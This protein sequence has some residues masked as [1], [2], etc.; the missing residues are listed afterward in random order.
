MKA[1]GQNRHK[2]QSLDGSKN[3]LCKGSTLSEK[4]TKC[5]EH[6]MRMFGRRH[7][8]EHLRRTLK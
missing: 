8:T 2:G 3:C 6:G 4:S 5:R 1:T 7:F